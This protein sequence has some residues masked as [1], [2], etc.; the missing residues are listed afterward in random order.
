MRVLQ[1]IMGVGQSAAASAE[2]TVVYEAAMA[3]LE[4]ARGKVASARG[5]DVLRSILSSWGVGGSVVS[6]PVYRGFVSPS[7]IKALTL[8]VGCMSLSLKYHGAK[9]TNPRCIGSRLW[10][11]M[12]GRLISREDAW[13]MEATALELLDFCL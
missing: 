8:L 7:E 3:Y 13:S 10:L 1:D 6:V 4:R 5:N 12:C 2:A 11:G 9:S